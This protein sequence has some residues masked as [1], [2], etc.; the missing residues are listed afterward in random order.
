VRKG[1]RKVWERDEEGVRKV[2][3][4]GVRKCVRIM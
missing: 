1:V 3:R 4:K 2:V